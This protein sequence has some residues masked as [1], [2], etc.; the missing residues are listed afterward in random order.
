MQHLR[1]S[2]IGP[3]TKAYASLLEWFLKQ[4]RGAEVKGFTNHRWNGVTTLHYARFC[5]GI[6]KTQP[7]LAGVQ[8]VVPTGTLSKAEMLGCF[9]T[10]YGR[11]DLRIVPTA[12]AIA[13]DRTLAT[14][15]EAINA[16]LWREAGYETPPTIPQMIEE[17]AG[18]SYRFQEVRT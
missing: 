5:R 11:R 12:T 4:P 2:I 9:A 13:I 17:L 6:I 3:E 10:A 14:E 8:H 16:Q 18:R 7:K 1:C 15:N